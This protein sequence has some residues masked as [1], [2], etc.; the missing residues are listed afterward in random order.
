M[1]DAAMDNLKREHD[2]ALCRCVSEAT[3]GAELAGV[4]PAVKA[5]TKP[6]HQLSASQ[7]R[8]NSHPIVDHKR[9]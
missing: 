3:T 4:F 6:E 7:T 9:K 2:R 8:R 1:Y 5:K